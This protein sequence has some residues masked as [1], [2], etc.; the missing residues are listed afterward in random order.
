M[1]TLRILCALVLIAI[2]C[3]AGEPQVVVVAAADQQK[4]G[5]TVAERRAQK[6]AALKQW[7]SDN[8]MLAPR[9]IQLRAAMAAKLYQE[10]GN[11][12]FTLSEWQ[13]FDEVTKW[14][15]IVGCPQAIPVELLG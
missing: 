10:K 9:E 1:K 13:V 2:P 7:A 14:C 11:K 12:P 3:L 8:L 15:I 6:L 4:A 5:D